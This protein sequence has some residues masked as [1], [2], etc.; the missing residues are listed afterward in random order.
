MEFTKLI[1]VINP[2]CSGHW[3]PYALAFLTLPLGLPSAPGGIN[4]NGPDGEVERTLKVEVLQYTRIQKVGPYTRFPTGIP[5]DLVDHP[6][7][8]SSVIF[9]FT[10]K[11]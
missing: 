1:I 3:Y 8:R 6:Q 7:R 9:T 2:P 4:R 10:L 5:I 11:I